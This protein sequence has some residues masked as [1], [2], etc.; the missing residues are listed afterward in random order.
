MRLIINGD[1]FGLSKSITDGIIDG[2][3]NGFLTSTSIMI[4]MQFA[5]Y[6][7]EQAISNGINCVGLHINLTVG[8]PIIPNDHL[9]DEKGV[10]LYNRKQIENPNLTYE[11][12]YNEII[13]QIHLFNEYSKGKIK[14]DHFDTHHTLYDNEKIRKA[15]IEISNKMDLPIR[16][17]TKYDLPCKKPDDC[18]VDFTI[19]NVRLDV[20]DKFIRFNKDKDISVEIMSHPGYVDDYTKT[21]TS[22]LGREN[23]LKVLKAAKDC[24]L[25]DDVNLI[26]F[27][28]L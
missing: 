26:R 2:I 16:N 4:N 9:T 19:N 27:G 28:E 22:Y 8:K 20:L 14:L 25:F 17:V 7:I 6:A 10:F 3:K 12:A 15:I 13:A 1:D 21:V 24:G 23:E 11:D 18:F 5:K